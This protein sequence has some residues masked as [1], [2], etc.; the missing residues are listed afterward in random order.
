MCYSSQKHVENIHWFQNVIFWERHNIFNIKSMF[1]RFLSI[2]VWIPPGGHYV[3][4]FGTNPWLLDS[5]MLCS[6]NM[7]NNS[8][9][10]LTPFVSINCTRILIWIITA[11]NVSAND[12][13]VI[14]NT[15]C[16]TYCSQSEA[17]Y[18]WS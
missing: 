15:T 8:V 18:L 11:T 17:W 2:L 14:W 9:L 1:Q 6:K 13:P 3:S 7:I 4:V 10:L 5:T 16:T 12:R